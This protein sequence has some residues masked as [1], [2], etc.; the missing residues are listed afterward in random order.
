MWDWRERWKSSH[1]HSGFPVFPP[2]TTKTNAPQTKLT[3]RCMFKLRS[4]DTVMIWTQQKNW[5]TDAACLVQVGWVPWALPLFL[6]ALLGPHCR[7]T[8]DGDETREHTQD[9]SSLMR[10]NKKEHWWEDG[11][12]SLKKSNSLFSLFIFI[13]F[14]FHFVSFF[15]FLSSLISVPWSR[16]KENK[17]S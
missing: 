16:K 9:Y 14:I 7:A 3:T 6:S 10:R 1:H 11:K 5:P 13:F 4:R 12:R 2:M 17:A 8:H 15:S